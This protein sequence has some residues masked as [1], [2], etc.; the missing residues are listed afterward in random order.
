MVLRM[1]GRR[2]FR[3]CVIVSGAAQGTAFGMHLPADRAFHFTDDTD[4]RTLL[5]SI[6]LLGRFERIGESSGESTLPVLRTCTYDHHPTHWIAAV[7]LSGFPESENGYA[8]LCLPRS[9]FDAATATDAVHAWL[10]Q[11]SPSAPE[12][13]T[14]SFHESQN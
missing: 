2:C 9:R 7:H 6:D 10:S 8:V 3:G 1:S 4:C 5:L 12:Q 11:L 14:G 13:H